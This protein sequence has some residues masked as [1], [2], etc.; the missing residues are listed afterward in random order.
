MLDIVHIK[1]SSFLRTIFIDKLF[2]VASVSVKN[3][4]LLVDYAN[5]PYENILPSQITFITQLSLK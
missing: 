2:I 4:S 5:W 3:D 1:I